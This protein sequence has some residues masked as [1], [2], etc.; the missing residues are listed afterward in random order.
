ML[1]RQNSGWFSFLCRDISLEKFKA[2]RDHVM[3]RAC[4]ELIPVRRNPEIRWKL[5]PRFNPLGDV[6]NRWCGIQLT[7][8]ADVNRSPR[9]FVMRN[10]G[11]VNSALS[12]SNGRIANASLN[13]A[14]GSNFLLYFFFLN[15]RSLF[16]LV[17]MFIDW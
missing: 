16:F 13:N 15:S 11:E 1:A 9:N 3:I 12:S 8:A 10:I 5:R 17:C 7:R 2:R 6:N 4:C 14:Q